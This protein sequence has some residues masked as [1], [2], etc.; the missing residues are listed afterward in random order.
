MLAIFGVLLAVLC[1]APW[2]ILVI[3]FL[4]VLMDK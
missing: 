2:Y 1:D 3:C 4:Y